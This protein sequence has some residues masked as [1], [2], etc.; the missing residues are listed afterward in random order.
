M[1]STILLMMPSQAAAQAQGAAVPLA[2]A[3]AAQ[4]VAAAMLVKVAPRARPAR[5][6][7]TAWSF[8]GTT[9]RGCNHI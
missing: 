4:P 5:V 2:E 6:G 9:R 7:K 1:D 3:A 8:R